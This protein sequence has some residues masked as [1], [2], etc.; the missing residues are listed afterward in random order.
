MTSGGLRHAAVVAALVGAGLAPTTPAFAVDPPQVALAVCSDLQI[1]FSEITP[2]TLLETI[3]ATVFAPG[4]IAMSDGPA[5]GLASSGHGYLGSA[6][7]S[8]TALVH[9]LLPATAYTFQ[10][11]CLGEGSPASGSASAMVTTAR[12]P[13]PPPVPT[14]SCPPTTS[15]TVHRLA[16][17]SAGLPASKVRW[18]LD[19]AR[20]YARRHKGCA[21]LRELRLAAGALGQAHLPAARATTVRTGIAQVLGSLLRPAR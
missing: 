4:L 9:D 11:S 1:A 16:Q 20:A 7:G 8:T 10:A 5:G 6:T 14:R 21:T 12:A 13:L 15:A 3:T 17:L 18:R 19:T 2:T